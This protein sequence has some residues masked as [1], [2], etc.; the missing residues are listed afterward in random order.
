[1]AVLAMSLQLNPRTMAALAG[2][3][4]HVRGMAAQAQVIEP[5]AWRVV[6]KVHHF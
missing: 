6:A 1:M 5:D 2:H 3:I 4:G